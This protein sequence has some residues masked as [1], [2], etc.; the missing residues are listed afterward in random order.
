M[1]LQWK[2][3]YNAI[4]GSRLDRKYQ[5]DN[6]FYLYIYI[7]MANLTVQWRDAEP[8]KDS[9]VQAEQAARWEDKINS[10]AFLMQR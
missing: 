5:Y 3:W 6:L 9:S 7:F 8:P 10:A 2:P 4:T 1:K